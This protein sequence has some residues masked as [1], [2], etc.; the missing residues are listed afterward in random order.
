LGGRERSVYIELGGRGE[1]G[2]GEREEVGDWES[3]RRGERRIDRER[4]GGAVWWWWPA[5]WG[6]VG[7]PV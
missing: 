6:S 3:G 7:W 1:Q 4:G 5:W 2:E